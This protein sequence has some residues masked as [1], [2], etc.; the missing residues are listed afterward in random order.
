[1]I[2][3]AQSLYFQTFFADGMTCDTVPV[4]L[5]KLKVLDE[6]SRTGPSIVGMGAEGEGGAGTHLS[7]ADSPFVCPLPH[8]EGAGEGVAATMGLQ[9]GNQEIA[10][11]L[12]ATLEQ[13]P[14]VSSCVPPDGSLSEKN[15][16][17]HLFKALLWGSL[18]LPVEY[19]PRS[20]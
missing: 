6:V 18:F 19:N 11:N 2:C 14:K 12:A 7:P 17:S 9:Q 8:E 15:K 5:R 16:T 20:I 4:K 10:K 3:P 1:M 13:L